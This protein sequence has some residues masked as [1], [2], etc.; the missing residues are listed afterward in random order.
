MFLYLYLK[1][2]S[3]SPPAAAAWYCG[4]C[5]LRSHPDLRGR[6]ARRLSSA[7]ENDRRRFTR[8][9]QRHLA[10]TEPRR[11]RCRCGSESSCQGGRQRGVADVG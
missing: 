10:A 1:H 9:P 3:P 8:S 7:E 4:S 6:L 5:E 11:H 2:I